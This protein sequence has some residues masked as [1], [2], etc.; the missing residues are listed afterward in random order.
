MIVGGFWNGTLSAIFRRHHQTPIRHYRRRIWQIRSLSSVNFLLSEIR[1][2]ARAFIGTIAWKLIRTKAEFSKPV[3][4]NLKESERSASVAFGFSSWGS[5]R[6][7][8][9]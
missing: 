4:Q 1:A 7:P 3:I 5:M 6:Q 2:F 9:D 8:C